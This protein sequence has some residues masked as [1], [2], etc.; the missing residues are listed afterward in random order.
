MVNTAF[1]LDGWMRTVVAG[2]PVA[3]VVA[4]CAIIAKHSLMETWI[5]MAASAKGGC[6]AETLAV[7]ALAG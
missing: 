3:G 4:F 6:P 2:I 7:A 5:A 1:I